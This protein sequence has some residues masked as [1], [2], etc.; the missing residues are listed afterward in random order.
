MIYHCVLHVQSMSLMSVVS[1]PLM[2]CIAMFVIKAFNFDCPHIMYI[3]TNITIIV[4]SAAVNSS[5]SARKLLRNILNF[6]LF[7]PFSALPCLKYSFCFDTK[8][9][10]LVKFLGC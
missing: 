9:P 10:N 3:I 6:L 1:V 2:H 7:L 8:L 5:M 4:I